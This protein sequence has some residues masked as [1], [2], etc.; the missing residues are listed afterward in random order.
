MIIEYYYTAESRMLN[1]PALQRVEDDNPDKIIPPQGFQFIEELIYG[2]WKSSYRSIETELDKLL[3]IFNQFKSQTNRV[4]MFK[5]PLV[6]DALRSSM[7][8]LAA[9]GISGFDSPIAQLSLPEGEATLIGI[10]HI[11]SA[12][13]TENKAGQDSL[14]KLN[15][16]LSLGI[17]KL[18]SSSSF[19]TFDRMSF[20]KTIAEPAYALII[21][22]TKLLGA[23]LPKERRPIN[24]AAESFFSID[25]FDLSFFSPNERYRITPERVYL[26]NLL[27]NDPVLSA[28]KNRTCG[29][30]HKPEL[31]FTDGLKTALS[32]D[33]KT[34]LKR[35]TPTLLNSAF[36]TKQF[37]D[38][39][40][41]VLE[42]QLSDVVH[43]QEEMKGSLKQSVKDLQ[44]NRRYDSLFRKAYPN[45]DVAISQYNIANAISSYTRSLVGLNSR[46]D[47]YMRGDQGKM[48]KT[49]INGFNLFM[50]KAKCATCHFIPLFNGLVPPEFTE[51]ESEVLAVPLN[52]GQSETSAGS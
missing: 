38:S 15:S 34:F 36:Q 41:S 39:R 8:K 25:F 12:I 28:T 6:W 52:K 19:N 3:I 18:A 9:M 30:C 22:N 29:G 5:D 31:A 4:F 44:Q 13:Q 49:E 47:L 42:N 32:V 46:F 20:I 24:T 48:T 33:Q 23:S 51:T 14:A 50:G 43:N 21:Q 10:R 35:N 40:T 17:T 7:M 2:D 27:F 37:Y 1:G 11:L 45:D 16:V 26:G